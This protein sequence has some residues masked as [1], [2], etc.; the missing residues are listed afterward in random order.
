MKFKAKNLRALAE[1]VV[2][3]AKYFHYRSSY[4]ITEFFQD[5]GLDYTHDGST[6]HRWAAEV[7]E[8]LLTDT[9]AHEN[10]LPDRFMYVLRGMMDNDEAADDDPDRSLALSSLNTILLKEGF[11][12]FFSEDG[13][14]LARHIG[15]KIVSSITNPHR[16]FTPDEV[17]RRDRL[18]N[19]LDNCSE[20]E[21]IEEILLPLFRQLGF[22]RISA[23]GHTDKALEYG[24][25][26]WMKYILPTTHNL[27]F[28]IQVKKG[29]LHASGKPQA[30]NVNMSEIYN[31][32]LMMLGHKIFDPETNKTSLVDHAFIIAGG[33]ITK[34]AK[35]W[36]VGKLNATQRSQIMFMDRND[37]L[38][39]FTA[40]SIALP[41]KTKI[42]DGGPFENFDLD[43]EIPF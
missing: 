2:G 41:K 21:L 4:F 9:Q 20:D 17:E 7:L 39:L 23:T 5:C 22:L 18:S 33:E 37:I 35:N 28:G 13:L 29:K 42:I 24:K 26:I 34:Q 32:T 12:V 15:S 6:R 25:D 30:K 3:D 31:Q 43:D 10:R 14:L 19:Y 38:N 16:R 27:Y 8:Q 1:M 36:L 40:A 11:E